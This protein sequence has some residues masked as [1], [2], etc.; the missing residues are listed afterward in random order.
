MYAIGLVLNF[1]YPVS[2]LSYTSYSRHTSILYIHLRFGTLISRFYWVIHKKLQ[3]VG[4]LHFAGPR[5][6]SHLWFRVPRDSWAYVF[7]P[8]T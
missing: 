6:H 7:C 4:R 5:Q 2:T 1:L 8:T 3:S